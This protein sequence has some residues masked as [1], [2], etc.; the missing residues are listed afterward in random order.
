MDFW[1][2][3]VLNLS[4]VGG[5][6]KVLNMCL[7]VIYEWSIRRK[8]CAICT[9]STAIVAN[10]IKEKKYLIG[11]LDIISKINAGQLEM[12]VL[13]TLKRDYRGQEPHMPLETPNCMLSFLHL[14][15][16]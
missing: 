8:N 7:Y 3:S 14:S 12:I 1:L 4:F 10:S 15:I 11:F 6:I 5:V 13:A 16:Q 9:Q 2:L